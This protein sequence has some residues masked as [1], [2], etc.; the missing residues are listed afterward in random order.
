M[1]RDISHLS[2]IDVMAALQRVASTDRAAAVELI[3]YLG[4]FG[5]RRLYLGAS[6]ASLFAYCTRVLHLSEHEAYHRIKAARAGRRFPRILDLLADGSLNLTT[7]KLVAP[8]LTAE[9]HS[10][11]LAAATHKTRRE[12]EVLLARR[13]PEADRPSS[14]RRLPAPRGGDTPSGTEPPQARPAREAPTPAEALTS[15]SAH[16]SELVRPVAVPATA[17]PAILRP[18]AE[19]RYRISFTASAATYEQLQ[20]AKDLLSHAVPSGDTAEIIHRA[21]TLLVN[22]LS[23]KKFAATSRPRPSRSSDADS[24]RIPA[25]VKRAVWARDG[26]ACAFFAVDGRRC[27][28]RKHL[29]FHHVR[30]FAEGGKATIA[31]IQLRCRPHNAHEAE[32]FYAASRA[33]RA[34]R[35]GPSSDVGLRPGHAGP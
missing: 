9:N 3:R 14:V 4:E 23:R 5:A 31:N 29:E 22:D 25:A 26:G 27:E 34:T 6:C 19:D 2:D 28:E 17:R 21:L 24:R 30:P 8:H 12:V 15:E 35:P 7:V 1:E 18:V 20:I 11:L 32:T 16:P 13:F 10:Q 33:G